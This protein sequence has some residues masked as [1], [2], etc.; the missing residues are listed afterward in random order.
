MAAP[1]GQYT[2]P[3]T[4]NLGIVFNV[5]D[6]IRCGRQGYW[7]TAH[8]GT[9]GVLPAALSTLEIKPFSGVTYSITCGC[10]HA[11]PHILHLI[12][13]VW[14]DLLPRVSLLCKWFCITECM[15]LVL[16]ITN[17]ISAGISYSLGPNILIPNLY[18]NRSNLGEIS[19]RTEHNEVT[20]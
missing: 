18:C 15:W 8:G 12:C 14:S 11:R 9:H 1:P 13:I 3:A 17:M 20:Y 10:V 19:T 2:E 6:C 16:T 5:T 4:R 7:S